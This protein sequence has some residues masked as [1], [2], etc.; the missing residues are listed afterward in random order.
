M[1]YSERVKQYLSKTTISEYDLMDIS[2]TYGELADICVAPRHIINSLVIQ[3]KRKIPV[4]VKKSITENVK[5]ETFSSK[6]VKLIDT[7]IT[8]AQRLAKIGYVKPNL[9]NIY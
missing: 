5:K 4:F 2:F 8:Y 1:N 7:E 3:R 9:S 6:K